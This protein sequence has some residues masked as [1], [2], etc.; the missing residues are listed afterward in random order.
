MESPSIVLGVDLMDRDHLRL[1]RLLDAAAR[2]RN[3]HL[4]RL[5]RELTAELDAHFGREEALMRDRGVP[6]WYCHL[7]QHRMLIAEMERK[8]PGSRSADL[9]RRLTVVARQSILAHIATMDRMAA[10][11]LVGDLRRPDFQTLRLPESRCAE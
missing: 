11:F 5:H 4:P 2:S 8:G 7:T 6:G 1:E 3:E 10:A 9:R